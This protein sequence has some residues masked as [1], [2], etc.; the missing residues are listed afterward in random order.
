MATTTVNLDPE[1]YT[2]H[3]VGVKWDLTKALSLTAAT[4][5]IDRENV[6]YA[7]PDGTFIQTGTSQVKGAEVSLT[8]HVTKDWQVLASYSRNF[9]ELTNATSPTL[10]A[11]T[12]LALLPRDTVAIWNR[13]QFAPNWGAGVGVVYH[14]DM[15]A[16]LQPAN[17]RVQ[18][19]AYTTVDAALYWKALPNIDVQ[20]NFTNIFNEK[21]ILTADANDNLT[22]GAPRSAVLS[23]RSKF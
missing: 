10:T 11:G 8:G 12:P 23:I 6:R 4:Y 7:N 15:F 2:N 20:L 9:G 19:P 5:K 21:Y 3:E 16:T 22:P 14:S 18:L 17:N 13:Y 1:K